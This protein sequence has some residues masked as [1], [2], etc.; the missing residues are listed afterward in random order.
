MGR[1]VRGVPA[2]ASYLG[3]GRNVAQVKGE[4]VMDVSGSVLLKMR[5]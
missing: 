5:Y 2:L 3:R 4:V 1:C